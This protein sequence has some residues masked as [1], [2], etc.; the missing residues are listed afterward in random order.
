MAVN[1]AVPTVALYAFFNRRIRAVGSLVFALTALGISGALLGILW[2]GY[3]E[4]AYALVGNHYRWFGLGS[5][6][7]LIVP[8]ILGSLL[9]GAIGCLCCA[10]GAALS[11]EAVLR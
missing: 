2:L 6:G 9:F 3:N 11:S 5:T 1:N 4:R 7:L 10:G 8:P